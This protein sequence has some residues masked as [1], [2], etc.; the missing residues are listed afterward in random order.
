MAE[1]LGNEYGPRK[2]LEDIYANPEEAMTSEA[3]WVCAWCY[4]CYNRCPQGLKVPEILLSLRKMAV[5]RGQTEAFDKALQKIVKNV[6]LPLV[7][8][9]VCY[10]PERAGLKNNEVIERIEQLRQEHVSS[11]KKEKSGKTSKFKVAIIGSGPAGLAAAYELGRKNYSITVFESLPE[12]GGMLRKAIPQYRLPK[13]LVAKEVEFI[14][15]LGVEVKTGTEIGK[16]LSFEDLKKKGYRAFFISTGAHKSQKLKIEGTDKKG[17]ANA[18][19]LLWDTNL[20]KKIEIGNKVVVIGGGNVAI[21]AAR[22][23]HCLGATE[24]TI[25]YRRSRNEMPANL[26]EVEEAEHEGVKIEYLV[27]PKKILGENDKVSAIECTRMRLD[28]P[29]ETGRRKAVPIEGS[30]FRLQADNVILAIGETPNL[31]FLPKDVDLN[32]DGTLWV[33]PLTMETTS[34]G[35]FGGGDA[36]SGPASV[37]EAIRD[38]KHAAESIETYLRSIQED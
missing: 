20:E 24:V 35:F 11:G 32:E 25:L 36:V 1:M 28:E 4:R 33:N 8:T 14:E 26:R 27:S 23:A 29:D 37:I 21:D 18:L 30:E 6:P 2:L 34:A 22:T 19:D 10:H 5:E 13:K 15:A 3:I 31:S 9:F 38:G 16:S 17:V 12:A 7:A